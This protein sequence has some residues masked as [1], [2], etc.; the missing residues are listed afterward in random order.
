MAGHS[1][2]ANIK[3]KK[4]KEDAKK[5]V[6]FTKLA[7]EIMIATRLSSN[8]DP[9]TN[10]RLRLVVDK[11]K[12][13]N[14]PNENIERAIKKG[15]GT[16]GEGAALEEAV[17]EGYGPGG[18]A[19]LLHALTDNRNRTAAEVRTAFIRSGGSLGE[20][21]SVAWIF[22]NKAVVTVE[23]VETKQAEEL[24]L[25][26]ID[27]GADDFKVDDGLLEVVGPPASL[28]TLQLA[29]HDMHVEIARGDVTMVPKTTM[30]LDEGTALQTLQLLD[31]LDDLD[32]ISQVFTNADFPDEA[33]ERYHRE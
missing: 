33:L 12:Q 29:I 14:M 13:A 20:A 22:E 23:G 26:V 4:G 28:D 16:G 11:A 3:H 17:Y 25:V 18:A 31:K 24:A 8:G 2:W 19:I 5:G 9:L 10:F 7:K 21:G 32:D 15:L 1:K 6:V 27:A 30:P